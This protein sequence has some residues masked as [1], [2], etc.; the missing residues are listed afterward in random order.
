MTVDVAPVQHPK[1]VNLLLFFVYFQTETVISESDLVETTRALQLVKVHDVERVFGF[2][3]HLANELV[4]AFA[5]LA[6]LP[7][8]AAF[9]PLKQRGESS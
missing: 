4:D 2:G 9:F 6:W 5:N 3:Q 1:N 7:P 8:G